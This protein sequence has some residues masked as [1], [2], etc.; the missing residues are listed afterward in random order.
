M[1]GKYPQAENA[2]YP[3][4]MALIL[5]MTSLNIGD[6]SHP[7]A[8]FYP[9]LQQA[10]DKPSRL[11]PRRRHYMFTPTPISFINFVSPSTGV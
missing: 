11:N 10:H 4:G 5:A 6:I 2:L 8:G 9:F 1:T 7:N 3:I